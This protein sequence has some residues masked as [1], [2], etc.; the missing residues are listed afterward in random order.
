MVISIYFLHW[1][2]S[3]A[4]CNSWCNCNCNRSARRALMIVGRHLGCSSA[5]SSCGPVCTGASN[6]RSC[7]MLIENCAGGSFWNGKCVR[8]AILEWITKMLPWASVRACSRP[9]TAA[10]WTWVWPEIQSFDKMPSEMCEIQCLPWPRARVL[11]IGASSLFALFATFTASRCLRASR[12]A[13]I[14]RVIRYHGC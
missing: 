2:V 14:I 4:S 1:N 7:W 3:M 6:T 9:W 10:R 5:T 12:V 13:C 8:S 11:G